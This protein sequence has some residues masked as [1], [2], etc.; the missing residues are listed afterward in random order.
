MDEI[1][2]L[3]IE[4]QDEDMRLDVFLSGRLQITRSKS[5]RLIEQEMVRV[6]GLSK[7]PSFKLRQGMK[8]SVNMLTP[9]EPSTLEPFEMPISVIY[10]DEWIIVIDKPAGLV[11][12]P[13]AGNRDKTLANALIARYPDIVRVGSTERP[14]I[15]HR[16]DKL[17]SGVMVV[18]RND[19]S[20]VDLSASFQ[21]HSHKRVYTALCY[22]HW[23]QTSGRIETFMNRHPSDRK[24][25]SSKV[26]RGRKAITD[27]RVVREWEEISMME[28]SLQ[29]GRTHQIRVHLSDSDHPV[30]A[31]PQYGGKKRSNSIANARIRS[32]VK[33][34]QRQM[35]HASILGITHPFTKKWMEFASAL[36]A[37]MEALIRILD[38]VE[39]ISI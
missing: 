15:V 32:F 7:K 5:S 14:G 1:V 8:I 33:D 13:G 28:L 10:E 23:D 2:E 3:A 27:W 31:D 30:L 35:L 16:L 37:D 21:K 34:I 19:R 29:T 6:D 12:H 36:P 25:M 26:T 22:G 39:G 20:Y 17:T 4:A 38:E 9:E 24:R 11:V 18:A